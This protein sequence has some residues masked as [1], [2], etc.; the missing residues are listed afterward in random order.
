MRRV[1]VT[2][3]GAVTPIGNNCIDFWKSVKEGV[4]GI[5]EITAFDTTGRKVT[6][7]AE[8]KNFKPEEILDKRE[9]RRMD[10]FTQFAVV[11]AREAFQDAS[12][13]QEEEDLSRIGVILSSGIGGIKTIEELPMAKASKII[14]KLKKKAEDKANG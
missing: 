10:R 7:A 12:L 6:L 5:D 11:S 9:C 4:C 13:K 8:V 2:G 1:V 3:V 14:G